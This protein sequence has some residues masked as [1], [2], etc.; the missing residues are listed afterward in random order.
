MA[1]LLMKRLFAVHRVTS[2]DVE[3][4]VAAIAYTAVSLVALALVPMLQLSLLAWLVD[5]AGAL[6]LAAASE[7][8]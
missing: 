5:S 7:N 3:L 4:I 8:W 6:A 2:H 1:L